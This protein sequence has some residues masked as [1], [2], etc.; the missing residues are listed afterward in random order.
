M[1]I[2]FSNTHYRIPRG[3][4]NLLEGLTREVLR[5]QPK[6]I[7]D[8][9]AKYFANLLKK[10]EETGFDPTEWGAKLE[11]RFY[12]NYSF[13]SKEIREQQQKSSS[14]DT[15]KAQ[16]LSHDGDQENQT[17]ENY[18]LK[19]KASTTIQAAYRGHLERKKVKQMK[20][21]KKAYL[22]VSSDE[23]VKAI[24]EIDSSEFV[25]TTHVE[26]DMTVAGIMEGHRG[27]LQ[28]TTGPLETETEDHLERE[29]P[30]K[31]QDG[32]GELEQREDEYPE[33]VIEAL[34][35]Q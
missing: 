4:G 8:F 14:F 19:M 23:K 13:K 20:S 12:N 16:K 30:A 22:D 26:P 31:K 15:K 29:S 25:G 6:D 2:P 35:E 34:I 10:R 18:L 24:Q 7:P 27:N 33:A 1:A 21:D 17:S 11:D 3:F 5:E 9:A 28:L 32:A